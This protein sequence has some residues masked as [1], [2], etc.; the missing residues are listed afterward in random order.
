MIAFREMFYTI[1]WTTLI[2]VLESR[3]QINILACGGA[4]GT[5]HLIHPSEGVAFL[6]QRVVKSSRVSVSSLLFHPKRSGILFCGLSSGEVLVWDLAGSTVNYPSEITLLLTLNIHSEIFGLAF[7]A[8]E[9]VLLVA[10]NNG[11]R[12]WNL[13][14]ED[15][16]KKTDK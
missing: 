2:N 1:A 3:P 8:Q 16:E 11:L 4:R 15:L 5:I 7:S 13:S 6:E 12:G 9:N 14:H 10:C